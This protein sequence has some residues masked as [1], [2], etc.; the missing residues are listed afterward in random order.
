MSEKVEEKIS[1]EL[2]EENTQNETTAEN[3]NLEEELKKAKIEIESLMDSWA[4]E[5]AEFQNFKRRASMDYINSKKE[6]IKNFVVKLLT[7][8]DDLERVGMGESIVEEA[9][10]F[11][12]GVNLIKR[13]LF[14]VLE[15]ENIRKVEPK[16]EVFDP[17]CMEAIALEESGDFTEERVLEVYQSGYEMTLE[18]NEKV[19]LRPSRVKVGRPIN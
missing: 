14:S 10:P 11:V 2:N 6:A 12:E 3:K 7:P 18:N 16:G 9:K 4:R 15:R 19:T 17:M 5:R 8:L 1:G 13:E